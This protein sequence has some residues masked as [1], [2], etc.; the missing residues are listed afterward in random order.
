MSRFA[1]SASEI[2]EVQRLSQEIVQRFE[3]SESPEFLREAPVLA[4]ELPR[5]LRYFINDFRLFEPDPGFCFI[6]GLPVDDDRIGDTPKHWKDRQ[7]PTTTQA[8]EMYLVLVGSLLGEVIGWATQQSGYIVHDI[9][10]IPGHE[11]EQLGTGC[12]DPLAWHVEDAFH[13]CRGDYLALLCL[14]NHDQVATTWGTY[15]VSQLSPRH[16]DILFEPRYTIRPDES[17]LQRNSAAPITD[18][19]L[20][21]AYSQIERMDAAPPRIAV[22]YGSRERPYIRIDPY[23]MD[24]LTEDPEAQE[25]L[26]ALTAQIDSR[27]GSV[28]SQPGD[29]F[30]VDNYRLVHGRKPFKA[31][32]DGRDRWLK[33]INIARDLRKSR[34]LRE[35]AE[36]RVLRG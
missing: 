34:D 19:V 27:L 31:R 18:E 35:R 33:R 20:G 17:H 28:V 24:P 15:D 26:D 14:R 9:F 22:L 8:E 3:S 5:R 16:R 6:S 10:P 2:D 32:N 4:H 36:S 13:P 12:E 11:K 23:F 29:I 21:R 25:A 1:Y 30:I 7:F